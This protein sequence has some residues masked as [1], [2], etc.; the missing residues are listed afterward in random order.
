MAFSN[1]DLAPSVIFSV[2]ARFFCGSTPYLP[3]NFFCAAATP[4][5]ECSVS[6]ERNGGGL[7]GSGMLSSIQSGVAWWGRMQRRERC[8]F[9]FVEV[10]ILVGAGPCCWVFGRR[11]GWRGFLVA[12]GHF[13]DWTG[14]GYR[15]GCVVVKLGR[16]ECWEAKRGS[17]FG[18]R[19]VECA[20]E[21]AEV[22]AA[23]SEWNV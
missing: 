11:A 9:T 10:V 7:R 17:A 2:I 22:G 1:K 23:I 20:R 14:F 8:G 12:C 16:G 21:R 6:H 19:T 3:P 5:I 4:V 13:G 18:F 15:R